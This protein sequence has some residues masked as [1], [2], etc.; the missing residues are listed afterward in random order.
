MWNYRMGQSLHPERFVSISFFRSSLKENYFSLLS[1]GV[2]FK[3]LLRCD[4]IISTI[5][6]QDT[7]PNLSRVISKSV[8]QGVEE[9]W[10]L[11]INYLTKTNCLF[12]GHEYDDKSYFIWSLITVHTIIDR[13]RPLKAALRRADYEWTNTQMQLLHCAVV[14]A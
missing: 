10:E 6:D 9:Y 2:S 5:M 14:F 8:S 13:N 1:V 12:M 7:N 3:K 11:E 4:E